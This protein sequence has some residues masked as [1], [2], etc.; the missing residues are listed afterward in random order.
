MTVDRERVERLLD[1]LVTDVRSLREVA[2]RDGLATDD[3][4]LA[5]VSDWLSPS[6]SGTCS[7]TATTTST[8]TVPWRTCR[9]SATS[10]TS[11]L[12]PPAG[13]TAGELIA[14]APRGPRPRIPGRQR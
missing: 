11:R 14:G 8:T 12:M 7:S 6:A 1:R 3:I 2:A 10:R 4:A 5:S 9:A 13:S